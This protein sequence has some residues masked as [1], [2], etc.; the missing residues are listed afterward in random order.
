[1]H[2]AVLTLAAARDWLFYATRQPSISLDR[3]NRYT[4]N[5]AVAVL[6]RG[7]AFQLVLPDFD[8]LL[9]LPA[10]CSA[11]K[12][13]LA[14][15]EEGRISLELDPGGAAALAAISPSAFVMCL[16]DESPNSAGG[17]HIQSL[18]GHHLYPFANRWL[19]K[20]VWF[21]MT[22]NGLSAGVCEHA[23][24]DGTD[25]DGPQYAKA[26]DLS[27]ICTHDHGAPPEAV[28]HLTVLLPRRLVDGIIHPASEIVML[29][30][31]ARRL[32]DWVQTVSLPMR[33]RERPLLCQPHV[34]GPWS[35]IARGA[36]RRP[37]VYLLFSTAGPGM[38]P[39]AA[40]PGQ[41]VKIGFMPAGDPEDLSDR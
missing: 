29:A 37:A 35:A 28:A 10:I 11:F 4:S 8:M 34:C 16:D 32:L 41:D 19:D 40:V 25:A 2:A 20:P 9:E 17:R 36:R 1:M 30:T 14:A 5:Q 7:H 6:R 24:L 31:F 21:A 38:P 27:V 26:E 15:S 13:V 12:K 39:A 33:S 22:A 3:M 18:N 23:K